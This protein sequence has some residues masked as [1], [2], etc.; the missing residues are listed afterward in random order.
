MAPLKEKFGWIGIDICWW[1]GTGRQTREHLFKECLAWKEEIRKLWEEIGEA[2]ATGRETAGKSKYKG[3][4]GFYLG[5]QGNG[6]VAARRPGNTPIR[7]LMSDER[8]IPAVLSFLG[9][10]GCGKLKEGVILARR[11]P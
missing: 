8:C 5:R 11:T 1:C 2:T 4:K 10:T 7:V 6:F 9:R 3:R